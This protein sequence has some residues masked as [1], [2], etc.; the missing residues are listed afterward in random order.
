[1]TLSI[2][3]MLVTLL[4]TVYSVPRKLCSVLKISKDVRSSL[5]PETLIDSSTC[6]RRTEVFLCHPIVVL[7]G[8]V[9]IIT[10]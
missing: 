10:Q 4:D 2:S 6:T 3:V 7:R 8:L 5:I 1:M 9:C